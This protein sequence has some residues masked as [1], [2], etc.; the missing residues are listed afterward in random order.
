MKKGKLRHFFKFSENGR[1]QT[2]RDEWSSMHDEWSSMNDEWWLTHLADRE[3]LGRVANTAS[4]FALGHRGHP[5]S[6]SHTRSNRT[7]CHPFR[8]RCLQ[9]FTQRRVSSCTW[10][11]FGGA[12][13]TEAWRWWLRGNLPLWLLPL[14]FLQKQT[15]PAWRKSPSL[16]FAAWFS[17]KK[18]VLA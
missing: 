16:A 6:S 3:G 18:T 1:K 9:A 14:G 2:M 10:T 4:S 13:G 15:A 12:V 11:W 8:A 7:L 17:S 5:P